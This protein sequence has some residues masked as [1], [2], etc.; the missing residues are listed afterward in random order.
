MFESV[1]NV[2]HQDYLSLLGVSVAMFVSKTVH[3]LHDA[4]TS[5]C[6]SPDNKCIAFWDIN[7]IGIF[8][9]EKKEVVDSFDKYL[10]YEF[11]SWSPNGRSFAVV[12]SFTVVDDKP[13]LSD[14]TD[15]LYFCEGANRLSWTQ[16]STR[17]ALWSTWRDTPAFVL[18][19]NQQDKRLLFSFPGVSVRSM[20]WLKDDKLVATGSST[21]GIQLW[22][23]LTGE[24]N[25]VFPTRSTEIISFLSYTINTNE[26]FSCD[27]GKIVTL[28]NLDEPLVPPSA[29]AEFRL[30]SKPSMIWPVSN[31]THGVSKKGN[32]I[33]VAEPY[34]GF[35]KYDLETGLEQ[36]NQFSRKLACSH[37]RCYAMC[38]CYALSNNCRKLAIVQGYLLEV[39]HYSPVWSDK[40]HHLLDAETRKVVFHLM[41]VRARVEK[42]RTL[43]FLPM[44]VWL[45]I[46]SFLEYKLVTSQITW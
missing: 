10:L 25:F 11:C 24:P 37:F 5:L 26:L 30:V 6:W 38:K 34:Y 22:D 39:L 44:E 45:L 17:L 31:F 12:N 35:R 19:L 13:R 18:Q 9:T 2:T 4:V 16:D 3:R 21:G 27:D 42:Q 46:F 43:A 15:V 14:G 33:V 28:W 8:D 32:A 29:S 41:C 23:G 7:H 40:I 1:N 20:C 36:P